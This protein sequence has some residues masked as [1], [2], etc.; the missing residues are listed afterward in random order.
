M[1]VLNKNPQGYKE[2]IITF[3]VFSFGEGVTIIDWLATTKLYMSDIE[4]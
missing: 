2:H 1:S 3:I 4:G